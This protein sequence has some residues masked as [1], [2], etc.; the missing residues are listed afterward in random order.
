MGTSVLRDGGSGDDSGSRSRQQDTAS[1]VNKLLAFQ[2]S[3]GGSPLS[4]IWGIIKGEGAYDEPRLAPQMGVFDADCLFLLAA[5]PTP[6]AY[7]PG[8]M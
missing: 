2:I 8:I 3:D 5:S 1:G 4:L 6:T 7:I